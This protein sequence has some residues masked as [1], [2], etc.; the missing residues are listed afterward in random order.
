MT[1]EKIYQTNYQG[2]YRFAYQL[3]RSDQESKDLVQDVFLR[4][5]EQQKRVT[6]TKSWLYKVLYNSFLTMKSQADRHR[7]I[8]NQIR[9]IQSG[10]IDPHEEYDKSEL[11]NIIFTAIS[12]MPEKD[13]ALLLLY[14]NGLKYSEIAEI[15][16][17][18]PNSIGKI[19]ARSVKQFVEKLKREYH[20]ML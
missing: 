16:E 11:R 5:H 15:L 18:H 6:N 13:S 4:F 3:T 12:S 20:E 9:N 8:E 17:I 1:F 10:I 2:L 19:L 7:N 14:Y